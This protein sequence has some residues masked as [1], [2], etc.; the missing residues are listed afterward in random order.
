[1][2]KTTERLTPWNVKALKAPGR[3]SDGGNLYAVVRQS[4]AKTWAFLYR[5]QG[6]P[7]EAGGGSCTAVSLKQARTWAAEGRAMLHESPPR[8][9]KIVWH[10]RKRAALVPTFA[11]NCRRVS[12]RQ[13]A[14]MALAAA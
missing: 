6:K 4:G 2:A 13:I 7:T 14:A 5:W 3:Y 12:R 8:N 11:E 1:M 9:P 10:E